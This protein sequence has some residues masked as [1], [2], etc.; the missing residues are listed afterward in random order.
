M[1]K[2]WEIKSLGEVAE[3]ERG[4][5]YS[6]NDEVEFSSNVVLRSNNVDLIG[7]KLDF[8]ELKYIHD[9]IKI[10]ASKKVSKGSLIICTANGSKSHLGK[11]ALIEDDCDYAFGG[12]M[13]LIRPKKE[14]I[15]K[16][17]FYL[18]ISDTYKTFISELSDGAN[19]NNLKFSQLTEFEIP[20]PS[21]PIQQQI[22]SILDE[23][24]TAINKAKINLQRNLQ[25]AKELFRSELNGIFTSKGEGWVEKSL[26]E[27]CDIEYGYTDKSTHK[28]DYR[29]VRITDIDKN[30]ELILEDKKYI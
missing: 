29:Y 23:A 9:K 28:G 17:L 16:Y 5:T 11:V 1:K 6:K 8:T 24:F 20:V 13:G 4:L 26:E 18:M 30:G 12:F 27:I 25:N 10:P 15:S 3:F 19:I 7:S 2:G 22:V 14:I 21:I